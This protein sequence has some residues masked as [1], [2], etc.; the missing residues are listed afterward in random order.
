MQCSQ[1]YC[2][3]WYIAYTWMNKCILQHLCLVWTRIIDDLGNGPAAMQVILQFRRWPKWP[4][5]YEHYDTCNLKVLDFQSGFCI[6]M[7]LIQSINKGINL[8]VP[9]ANHVKLVQLGR[10]PP[11]KDPYDLGCGIKWVF[12]PTGY[13]KI[14]PENPAKPSVEQQNFRLEPSPSNIEVNVSILEG[15][16]CLST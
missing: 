1:S 7:F 10:I 4:N 5:L 6:D 9:W 8:D 12:F 2:H 13:C 14:N 15:S 16:F 11:T 3:K